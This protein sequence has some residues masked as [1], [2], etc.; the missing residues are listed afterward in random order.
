[1]QNQVVDFY[2]SSNTCGYALMKDNLT[3]DDWV[4]FSGVQGSYGSV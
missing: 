2:V 3:T 1:M 4:N